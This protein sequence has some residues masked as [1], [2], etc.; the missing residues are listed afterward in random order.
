MSEVGTCAEIASTTPPSCAA[1]FVFNS[2]PSVAVLPAVHVSYCAQLTTLIRPHTHQPCTWTILV[3]TMT[4]YEDRA[5][6]LQGAG[7]IIFQLVLERSTS[8]QWAEWLRAPLEHAAGTANHDLMQKLLRAGA[9]GGAGWK[10]CH[11][12]TLLHA[13]AEGG[14]PQIITAL[15]RAGAGADKNARTPGTGRTPL[16]LAILGGREAA[17]K[18]LIMVRADPNVVDE[19]GDAPLHLA[20][21]RGDVGLAENLL[22]IGA[23]H[24]ARDSGLNYPIHLAARRGQDEVVQSLVQSEA[25][26]DH[27]DAHRKT[28]LAV[29]MLEDR[30]STVKV[31]LTGGADAN[32]LMASNTTVLHKTAEYNKTASIPALIEAGASIEARDKNG[33]TPLCYAAF[34]GSCSAML[35]LLHLGADVNTKSNRRSTP[36][37]I[38]CRRGKADAADLLLRWGA[39]ETIVDNRGKTPSQWIP[40]IARSSEQDRPRLELLSKLL[41]RAPQDR[42]WRRRGFFVMCRV[43]LGRLRLVVEI[44]DNERRQERPNRRCRQGQVKVEVQVGVG[45]AR[46][47][48]RGRGAGSGEV[49]R[50]GRRAGG[51]GAGGGFDDVAAWLMALTNEDVFRNIVGFL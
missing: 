2:C 49:H 26:L 24:D 48:E 42:A 20:I 38:A 23:D 12:K 40:D 13:A 47:A 7:D 37:L 41:E 30:V 4:G 36:L 39:D 18:A 35:A 14:N 46:G 15:I 1:F 3:R 17:A 9:S 6:I 51:E 27:L 22:L 45:G 32:C 31:L 43:Y 21:E 16:H 50:T 10:G 29:A 19:K 33:F 5:S 34:F 28:P 8:E 44:P 25:N 11:G